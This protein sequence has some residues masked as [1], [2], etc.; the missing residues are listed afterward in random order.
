MDAR[1]WRRHAAANRLQSLLLIAALLAINAV[2]GSLLLG[3]E[4]LWAAL[5]AGLLAF[6]IEPFA[7]MRLTLRLYRARPIPPAAAPGLWRTL[8]TLADR[9]GLPAVPA[10]Y[11][12]PSPLLNAFTLGSRQRAAIALSDGALRGFS[13]RELAG[14]L[15]HE[16]AHVAHGDLRVMG[17]ADL[18]SRLTA[19]YA[20]AGQLLLLLALP[21]WA[22]GVVDID[23]GALLLLAA[24]PYLAL[25]AQLGLSRVRE[26][27]ADR[28]AAGLTGDPLGL[29][30]ALA[31]IESGESAWRRLLLPGWGNPQPSW[32][33]THPAT[34]ERIRRLRGMAASPGALPAAVFEPAPCAVPVRATP[35]WHAWGGWW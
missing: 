28:E 34:A 26:F 11:Y 3:D 1:T 6:V 15:A 19:V 10:L 32:L 4:G 23:W 18:V 20:L 21:A 24:S 17:L 31:R 14:V 33:R 22:L 25:L 29:A 8:A 12:V 2:A 13:P 7:G 30:S 16:L 5:A 27:D 9:A 35:R